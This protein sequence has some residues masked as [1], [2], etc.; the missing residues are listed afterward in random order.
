M[1][2]A[3]QNRLSQIL[4]LVGFVLL[5]FAAAALGSAVTLPEIDG[6][7]AALPKPSWNPP[8]WIFGPVWST[9]YLLMGIAAWLVWRQ[10]G[11]KGAAGALALFAV[12]LALNTLWSFLFF[13]GHRPDLAAVDIVL[14]GL[15]IVATMVAFSRHSRLAAVLLVP[16]LAWVTFAAV[17]NITIACM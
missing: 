9:L 5:C 3:T 4:G 11:L 15:A 1:L 14:L 13:G 16:Y 8:N 6:W 10:S 2:A 12:Q 17:L 7:Y